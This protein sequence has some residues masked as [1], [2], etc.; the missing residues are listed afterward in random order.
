MV[1]VC[2]VYETCSNKSW[3][4][5]FHKFTKTSVSNLIIN[6][7]MSSGLQ[8][9]MFQFRAVVFGIVKSLKQHLKHKYN[10]GR[11]CPIIGADQTAFIIIY[12]F[13]LILSTVKTINVPSQ[14]T[15]WSLWRHWWKWQKTRFSDVGDRTFYLTSVGRSRGEI[16]SVLPPP[17]FLKTNC[18]KISQSVPNI[19]I[20][21]LDMYS[22][23]S[24]LLA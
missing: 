13:C 7:T 22:S 2:L 9:L 24:S 8:V 12:F 21:T 1:Y 15:M 11:L 18:L 14:M 23:P 16:S 3:R 20:V 4:I 5:L 17:P 19:S 6:R 10:A